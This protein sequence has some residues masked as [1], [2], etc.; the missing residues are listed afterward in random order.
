[1]RPIRPDRPS[2][3]LRPTRRSQIQR[4]NAHLSNLTRWQ[5]RADVETHPEMCILRT[6]SVSAQQR[7]DRITGW[8]HTYSTATLMTSGARQK[9]SAGRS[10]H[11][12]LQE[13]ESLLGTPRPG[14]AGGTRTGRASSRASGQKDK[15]ETSCRT[16]QNGKR[17]SGAAPGRDYAHVRGAGRWL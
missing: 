6:R 2:P 17:R 16:R 4:T 8:G 5:L 7:G 15:R 1:M 10:G 3:S 12:G 9:G 13:T 11:S 14:S